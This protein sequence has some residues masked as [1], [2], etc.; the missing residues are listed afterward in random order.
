[1]PRG[2]GGAGVLEEN[3]DEVGRINVGPNFFEGVAEVGLTDL[4]DVPFVIVVFRRR[5][6]RRRRRKKT[7]VQQK[8]RHFASKKKIA[9]SALEGWNSKQK[10]LLVADSL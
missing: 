5:G 9:H 4:L 1:M 3:G 2:R 6:G 8:W 10:E 7:S